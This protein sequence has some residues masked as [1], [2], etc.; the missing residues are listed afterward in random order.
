MDGLNSISNKHFRIYIFT[1]V[2]FILTGFF[3]SYLLMENTQKNYINKLYIRDTEIASILKENNVSESIIISALSSKNNVDTKQGTEILSKT[4]LNI[5]TDKTLLKK[6]YKITSDFSLY[7]LFTIL[8]ILFSFIPIIILNQI[9]KNIRK[10]VDI[11]DKIV[12]NAKINITDYKLDGDL[13]SLIYSTKTLSDRINYSSEKFKLDKTH[14]KNF[15]SD[16]SHQIKTPLSVLKLNNDILKNNIQDNS[17]KDFILSNEN[18]I[19]K[20]DWLIQNQLK[21]ARLEADF[22]KYNKKNQSLI[23]TINEALKEIKPLINT[24]KNSLQIDID[25][26]ICIFQD[27]KWLNEALSNIIKN[28][29]EHT[30]NGTIKIKALD[31][32]LCIRLTISDTGSGISSDKLN[33]LFIRFSTSSGDIDSSSIGIGMNISKEIIENHNGKIRVLSEKNKGTTIIIDFFK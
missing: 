22:V 26:N 3:L 10:T 2:I 9:Y 6:H 4:G 24:N 7:F 17:L 20:L 28:A 16:V 32:P 14:L 33:N 15:I 21:L 8:I 29:A 19:I 23:S 18:Q 11:I 1:A 5:D 25:S 31:L 12:D 27:E 30:K 13:Y